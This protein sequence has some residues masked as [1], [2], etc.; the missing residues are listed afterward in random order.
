MPQTE[1]EH[2]LL[3][4]VREGAQQFL[5]SQGCSLQLLDEELKLPP[6]LVPPM[7]V[8]SHR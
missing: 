3:H 6:P 2:D 7:P 8:H 1:L 5:L 4:N